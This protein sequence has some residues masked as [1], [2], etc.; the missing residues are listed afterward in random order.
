VNPRGV[1]G[2]VIVG[3]LRHRF[4]V[5]SLAALLAAFGVF[6]LRGANYDV[7]PDFAPPQASIQTEAPGLSPEQVEM[8]V[9]R[10]IE[11]AI[12]GVPGV[13]AIRSNSIQG[14]SVV[15]IVFDA[16]S[17]VF[18]VR[19]Q[20]TEAMTGL[21]KQLPEGV[22]DP[23]LAPLTSST[24]IVVIVGV[25]SDVV[26]PMRLRTA[27]DWAIRPRLLA[28]PGVAKLTIYGGETKQYQIG[29]DP[30]RL[31]RFGLSIED[32]ENAGRRTLGVRG[33]GFIDNPN[34]RIV[35]EARDDSP[36]ISRLKH[37][38]VAQQGAHRLTL[39]EVATI[40][41]APEPP[42]GA[43]LIDGRPA[44]Q[45]IVSAQYGANTVKVAA[46]VDRAI[47]Q[48]NKELAPDGIALRNDVFRPA[49]FIQTALG[50]LAEALIVGAILVTGVVFLFLWNMRM[51]LIALTA[52]PLSLLAGAVAMNELGYSLNT[53]TLGGLGI[54]VGLIVDDAVIVVEN[55]YR[56]LRSERAASSL[57]SPTHSIGAA[58]YEVRS[59][60]VFAT[61]AIALVF[62][63]VLT[64]QDVA[65]RLFGPLGL[66]YVLAT[67]A[68]LAVALTVTPALCAVLIDLEHLPA[69]DP[70][71]VRGLKQRYRVA[72]TWVDRHLIM[73]AA[74]VAGVSIGVFSFVPS[75]GTSFIPELKE[76]HYVALMTLAPGSSLEES[77]R[78][79]ARVADALRKVPHVR[80]VAQRAGRADK[81]DDVY[82]TNY[83]EIEID[84]APSDAESEEQAEAGIRDALR[85]FPG[86][87]FAL[88]TFLSDRLDEVIS[89]YTA[90]VI[91]RAAGTDLDALD[92]V[93]A[94]IARTIGTV[95]GAVD[96]RL[97]NPT[98]VPGLS[99][100]LDD[101]ALARWGFK[102]LDVLGAVG[103]AYR[104]AEI[105]KVYEGDRVFA[106][107]VLLDADLRR[108]PQSVASLMLRAP[109]GTFVPLSELAAIRQTSGRYGVLHEG[110]RRVQIVTANT[111]DK[112]LGAFTMR[113]KANIKA[114]PVPPGVIVTITGAAEAQSRSM[115]SLLVN[116]CLA[117]GAM[118][119]LLS[120]TIR[121][122]RNLALVFLNL[123]FAMVGGV[124][125][126]L[127]TG[128]IASLGALVG[129]VTL[130]GITLRNAIMMV[131][132]YDQVA[133]TEGRP[134][135]IDAAIEGAADR[136]APILMTSL[137]TALGLL[138]LAL[139]SGEPGRELEGP[140]AIV[141][142]GGLVSSAAL[143]LLV[144][145]GVALR[146]GRFDQPREQADGIGE[147]PSTGTNA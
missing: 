56:R 146:W 122:A 139:G 26:S 73:V 72:L 75:L 12:A 66:A 92:G 16:E 124:V 138:P 91:V 2:H 120:F 13:A 107:A 41:A 88:R 68:S 20:L 44:I 52:I 14:L 76:G 17:D 125:A 99:I 46:A 77:T 53:M 48:L 127:A 137:A 134:W 45:I 59:A 129:F 106:A 54:A 51:A 84:L 132:H 58:T 36:A 32:V 30:A 111:T 94:Q 112:D 135:S 28:V 37:A 123:P 18:R 86:A 33:A 25:T 144:L 64:I 11:S 96:V 143:N 98:G 121:R 1:L 42:I 29:I 104:G 67:L 97:Q 55:V 126:L 141:I 24:G 5:L 89:G 101:E 108:S 131:A 3:S 70:P 118:V 119:L 23:R 15:T 87:T 49:R 81:A 128:G 50:N 109:A 147:A 8:L 40:T 69:Q 90:P 60:V 35:L 78:V 95:K 10:P 83:S 34:Q 136:L 63:P 38:V 47:A 103:T 61:L 133:R 6:S 22:E 65:G 4:A 140:M 102:A 145:P 71:L 113:V 9:T 27:A 116:S 130:F 7:F 62:V 115:T 110:G 74:I 19:Q 93:A 114:L 105:G 43:S 31:T 117:A 85:R 79:G 39:G 80:L 100:V 57:A 82:G 21:A 142:L